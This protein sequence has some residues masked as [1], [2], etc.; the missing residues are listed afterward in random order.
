MIISSLI[1][2]SSLRKLRDETFH[3]SHT[4]CFSRKLHNKSNNN[5]LKQLFQAF[6]I[7][8]EATDFVNDLFYALKWI[9]RQG[10][11]VAE[12]KLNVAYAGQTASEIE[13]GEWQSRMLS[14]LFSPLDA[15]RKALEEGIRCKLFELL[16]Q[17]ACF[18]FYLKVGG[19]GRIYDAQPGDFLKIPSN[20]V[21]P[22]KRE[23]ESQSKKYVITLT[24]FLFFVFSFVLG[25]SS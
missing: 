6:F 2:E 7:E 18:M 8:T 15:A 19:N 24:K 16:K 21:R 12:Q 22:S 1:V 5:I 9:N 20:Y 3:N 13:R 23:R 14:G 11:G 17:N 10:P 25:F 4:C